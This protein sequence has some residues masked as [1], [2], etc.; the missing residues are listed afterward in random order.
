MVP[1][2][3][4]RDAAITD[5]LPV[6]LRMSL[7]AFLR[8]Q[9][10][11]L[12]ATWR[13][14]KG[15][16]PM[17]KYAILIRGYSNNFGYRPKPAKLKVISLISSNRFYILLGKKICV[18]NQRLIQVHYSIFSPTFCGIVLV[19]YRDMITQN[20][21]Y[22]AIFAPCIFFPSTLTKGFAQSKLV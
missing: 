18:F 2:H 9:K 1:S 5:E 13:E 20:S 14:S 8:L 11:K 6:W 17:S 10:L 3:R 12:S 4:Q 15:Q 22:R 7:Q 19:T 21:V 16:A